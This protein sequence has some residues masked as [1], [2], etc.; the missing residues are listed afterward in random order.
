MKAAQITG[1]GGSEV[2]QVVTDAAK[3]KPASDQVLVEVHAASINP[4]DGKV[5]LGYMQE[6]VPLNFPAILGGD[7]AG[8]V[9]EV[10]ADVSDL[11]PGDE[12]YGQANALSGQGS[13]AEF[14]PAKATALAAK[15]TSLDLVTAAAMPL[16]CVSAYQALVDHIDLQSIQKILIHGGAGGIGSVA[17]QLAKHLG[18]YVATTVAPDDIDYVKALGA[19]EVLDYKSQD[20]SA[21]LINYDAVFDNVG[22]ETATKSYAVLKPGG[23][24]VSMVAPADEELAQQHGTKYVQQSTATTTDRLTKVAELIDQ[25]IIKPQI[26]QVF[27]LDQIAAAMDHQENG[28]PHGKV[29]LQVKSSQKTDN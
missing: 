8:V 11:M 5:R 19:D 6:M 20:F 17:I 21:L 12:V 1:Y 7:L 27:P 29:V 16:V 15:P 26:D 9:V 23:I 25:G 10:G 18:A 28:H 13:F 2:I 4:F 24:L 3:P 22:G 14:A